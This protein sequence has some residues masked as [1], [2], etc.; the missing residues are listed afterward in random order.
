VPPRVPR[1]PQLPS[2]AER[3][4]RPEREG[5]LHHPEQLDE[6]VDEVDLAGHIGAGQSPGVEPDTALHRRHLATPAVRFPAT[7]SSPLL[8]M[9]ASK[10]GTSG[11]S[12]VLG[13]LWRDTSTSHWPLGELAPWV[14]GRA[15]VILRTPAF[16]VMP[17]CHARPARR[18]QT[19]LGVTAAGVAAIHMN[20][21][22][23]EPPAW[24][25]LFGRGLVPKAGPPSRAGRRRRA[26][27]SPG[28]PC[29]RSS[30]RWWGT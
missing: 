5:S 21:S 20:H 13:D 25:A 16:M 8:A 1:R 27:P 28:A 14:V 2:T 9:P 10:P 30:H 7:W 24:L 18:V 29:R 4:A 3:R 6:G 19:W 23:G 17:F 15:R 11:R 22:M 26:A 12:N